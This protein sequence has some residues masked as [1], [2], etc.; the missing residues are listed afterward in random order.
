MLVRPV[1]EDG[2]SVSTGSIGVG[3]RRAVVLIKVVCEVLQYEFAGALE[4]VNNCRERLGRGASRLLVPETIKGQ[5]FQGFSFST[6]LDSRLDA[7]SHPF[8]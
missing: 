6:E 2:G 1:Q 7:P 5:S 3:Q 8:Q 4:L